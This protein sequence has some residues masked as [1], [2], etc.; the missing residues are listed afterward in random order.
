MN[1]GDQPQRSFGDWLQQRRR[2]LDLTQAELAR[3][4]GCSAITL[5]KLEAEER[6]P[7]K[8]I[9]ERLADVLQVPLD[10][11]PVF[12]RFAR[13]DPFAAPS[14]P[15]AASQTT[16]PPELPEAAR[17]DNAPALLSPVVGRVLHGNSRFQDGYGHNL[18]LQ[19]TSFI[20]REKETAEV[21]RLVS[22]GRLVTLTGA[23][24]SGKTQ[25][26]VEAADGL[27]DEFADGVWLVELA[28]L[29]DATLVPETVAAV[30]GHREVPGRSVLDVLLE[31][32]RPRQLLLLLDNCEHLI[33]GCAE[34]AETLLRACPY[35]TILATSREPLGVAGEISFH[36][37]SLSLPDPN[38][39]D[40]IDKVTQS[41]A[42]RLFIQRALAVLP[43][44]TLTSANAPAV[45]QVC[46]RLDGIPLAIELAAARLRMLPVEQIAA[47]LD[48]SFRLLT[49]GSRTALPRHQ[50]L[51]ALIDWSYQ[52]LSASEQILLRRL[53]VFAGGFTLE[54]AEAVGAGDAIPADG[55]VGLLA[56]LIDKSLVLADAPE[57]GVTARY[58]QLETIR[59]YAWAK[60]AASGE[61]EAARKRHATY[62]L[63]L[64]EA[65]VSSNPIQDT[66][67]GWQERMQTEQVNLRAAV[68]W[69]QA[70]IGRAELGLR[71]TLAAAGYYSTRSYESE[72]HGWLEWALAHADGVEHRPARGRLLFHLG[73]RLAFQ[74]N[75]AGGKAC[76]T[77]SL[78]LFQELGDRQWSAWVLGRLG[79]L[80]REQGDAAPARLRLEETVAL[81]RELGD[82][83]GIG[84]QLV[85]LGEV[86]VLQEDTAWA[87]SLLEEGLALVRKQGHPD[88]IGWALNHLGHVAQ[89]RG[90]YEQATRLHED[91]LPLFRQRGAR[92]LGLAWAY[93]GLGET[94]LAQG[95]TTRA[96][97]HLTK[98]LVLFHDFGHGP[99][100]A[101]CLAGLAGVAV[102]DEEPERAAQLWGAA[103]ALRQSIGARH[104]PAARAT[105]ERLMAAA[106]EQMGEGDF[107][108]AWAQGQAMTSEQAI[109]MALEAG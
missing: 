66:P 77:N 69:S 60:L 37:P 98:A 106:R 73:S 31:Q 51:Q 100:I 84:G 58:R 93:Q 55:V 86:A 95:K 44:F 5:R 34:L 40:A 109:E 39:F 92:Y 22:T 54:A 94:A 91:S 70:A 105:R 81:Y 42:A 20:G 1:A 87:T 83:Q 50:T 10:E 11:R 45:A 33:Q 75:Y 25:L 8:Q 43:G 32:L 62:Y 23:G 103:E 53:A 67:P 13:G 108:A 101:W 30:L 89:I 3:Q 9:A 80:A 6:R 48:D 97:T 68:T 90:E 63:T 38:Q 78:K 96:R 82:E 59:Q 41:E 18:P 65:G 27:L 47:R 29:A 14:G 35:L 72:W 19:L 46:R 28:P 88:S 56:R 61:A 76:M 99:S 102:L 71:L 36:V 17:H 79:W 24:G 52:L 7:S 104:A 107:M 85:T 26:A 21:R 12:L 64:A 49:G 2:A 57:G 16:Q 4:V 74:G 15:S